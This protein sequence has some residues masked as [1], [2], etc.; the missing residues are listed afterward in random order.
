MVPRNLRW[1]A[2]IIGAALR[3][4]PGRTCAIGL[5]LLLAA[6]MAGTLLE[7]TISLDR[8]LTGQLD[9]YGAGIVVTPSVQ[10]GEGR[11]KLL[12][13]A[14]RERLLAAAPGAITA[15]WRRL[16]LDLELNGQP[17]TAEG[18]ETAELARYAGW[19]QVTG[20]WPAA[21]ELLVGRN[22]AERLH[23]AAGT[24]VTVTGRTGS[25]TLPVAGIAASGEQDDL[26]ILPLALAQQL[27]GL[28]ALATEL[29]LSLAAGRDPA[30]IARNLQA[31]APEL[32]VREVRQ[33]A[34]AN[35]QLRD[36]VLLLVTLAALVVGASA[37]IGVTGTL[38]ATIMER[39]REIALL[40]AMGATWQRVA[41]LLAGEAMLLAVG[42][43][44][45]GGIFG[46]GLTAL[47]TTRIF[48]GP[49]QPGLVAIPAGLG[50]AV[51]VAAI[52]ICWPLVRV[53]RVAVAVSLRQ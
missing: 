40:K 21:E 49:Y 10:D 27:A 34:R 17:V 50:A 41:L 18:M 48:A 36:K 28:P 19:W 7:L 38:G 12:A 53:H 24:T 32:T 42:A 8:L 15:S 44:L 20:R 22:L 31:K 52:G 45:A 11:G 30:L 46:E 39:E 25:K 5:L 35:R 14:D 23:L 13:E 43:G 9:R 47:I 2:G 29:R 16:R 1:T 33:V 4:R 3:H 6:T 26:L 37:A 51:L